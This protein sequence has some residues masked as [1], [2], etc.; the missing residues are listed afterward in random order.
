MT[1]ASLRDDIRSYLPELLPRFVSLF[2]DAE[3]SRQ[4]GMIKPALDTLE[5]L[6]PALEDHLQLLL[7][8]LVRIICPSAPRPGPLLQ[9]AES[10]RLPAS[11]A[12]SG[13]SCPTSL[14]PHSQF[15]V[16]PLCKAFA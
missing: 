6:G 15:L 14:G 8:A 13:G 11:L 7:P 16:T 9:L 5:A 10:P 12:S 4:W 2:G 3:R 1:A